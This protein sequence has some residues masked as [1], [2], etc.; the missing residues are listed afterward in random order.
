MTGTLAMT[1]TSS[2]GKE[3]IVELLQQGDVFGLLLMLAAGRLPYQLS[4]RS[5]DK[6]KI[7]RVPIK[8]FNQLLHLHPILFQEFVAHLLICLHSSYRLSRGLAHD[9]VEIRIASVLSSLALKFDKHKSYNK[10]YTI[11]FTR[12]QLADLTGTTPETA[13]RVTREMQRSGLIDIK[14]PGIIQILNL[15]ALDEVVE[16]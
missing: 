8:N 15:Q 1:K 10:S 14:R 3:L 2:S 12:K 13:I 4:A 11:N 7:L 16:A 6:S 5:L 9:L